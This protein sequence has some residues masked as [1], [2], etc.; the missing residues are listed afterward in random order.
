[1][2][3]IFMAEGVK[4]T[5]IASVEQGTC[6]FITIVNGCVYHTAQVF[7]EGFALLNNRFFRGLL[8]RYVHLKELQI[9]FTIFVQLAP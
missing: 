2:D 1:M 8:T 9:P 3:N 7:E 6:E 4:E 5:I